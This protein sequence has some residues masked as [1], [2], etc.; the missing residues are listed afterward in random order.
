MRAPPAT[1]LRRARAERDVVHGDEVLPQRLDVDLRPVRRRVGLEHRDDRRDGCERILAP[2][3][4][5]TA[6]SSH[7][8]WSGPS[9]SAPTA[10][11][12]GERQDAT[13]V[14]VLVRGRMTFLGIRPDWPLK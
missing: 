11:R 2:G 10:V 13:P 7:R 5:R 9:R 12:Y 1:V 8:A 4:R 3:V 6:R 14:K